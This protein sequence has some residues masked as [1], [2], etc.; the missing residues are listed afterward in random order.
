MAAAAAGAGTGTGTG[1]GSTTGTVCLIV[2]G[3][4]GSGKTTFVQRL[5]S[6]LHIKGS[7]PYLI[8]LDPAMHETP[9][10]A[11]IDIRDTVN[12]KQ[13]MK[14]YGL[15]PNGGIVTALNLFATRFD[16]VMKFIEKRQQ[17]SPYVL[18]DTPGQ[19]EVFTWSASGTIITESLASTFPTVIVYVM[20]T[21]RSTSPVTFMSNMLYACSILYKT[22]LPFIV[23]MNKVGLYSTSFAVEWMTDFESFQ[24]ALNQESSFASNL[25]RSMSLVL[26]EFYSTLRVVGVSAMEGTGMDDFLTQVAE[27]VVEYD[28]EY[29]PH[30]LKMKQDVADRE[31]RSREEQL[32]R[33]RRDMGDVAMDPDHRSPAAAKS[34]GDGVAG[35]ELWLAAVARHHERIRQK[36]PGAGMSGV[37]TRQIVQKV[38]ALSQSERELVSHGHLTPIYLSLAMFLVAVSWQYWQTLTHS[39]EEYRPGQ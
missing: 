24:D 20:D 32:E 17:D 15:G 23:A 4:A 36:V 14:Q 27:A 18:I 22:R 38:E 16:Q 29:R 34:T 33:L 12:Y 1:T 2:L 11:N 35:W 21:S 3:M 5:T 37:G 13:V 28:L 8:N 10:P 9:V 39:S 26:D 31:L 30:Y 25:T 19:I 7:A 6:H